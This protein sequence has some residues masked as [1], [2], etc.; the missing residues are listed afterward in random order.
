MC[1]HK[2]FTVFLYLQAEVVRKLKS[3][4]KDKAVLQP[5][6]NKLLELKQ[7][8]VQAGGI[9]AAPPKSSGKKKK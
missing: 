1:V 5:E 2:G 4:T 7:Q 6:V 3:E 8:F 9:V